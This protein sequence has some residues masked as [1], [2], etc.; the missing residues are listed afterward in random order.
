LVSLEDLKE[1]LVGLGFVLEPVLCTKDGIRFAT[2]TGQSKQSYLDLVDVVDGMIEFDGCSWRSRG[3]HRNRSRANRR[4]RRRAESWNRGHLSILR[5]LNR[6]LEKL[7]WPISHTRATGIVRRST[8]GSHRRSSSWSS[9][10]VL[11]FAVHHHRGYDVHGLVGGY[12]RH[13]TVSGRKKG[14]ESKDEV[15]VAVEQGRDALDD[16]R[17]VDPDRVA[18]VSIGEKRPIVRERLTFVL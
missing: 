1:L 14:V 5:F 3:R 16:A 9:G 15:R 8:A 10:R 6:S 17:S 12:A 2:E 4:L 11:A 13:D 18:R 7:T